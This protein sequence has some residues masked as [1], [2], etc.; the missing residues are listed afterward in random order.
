MKRSGIFYFSLVPGK[1]R[2]PIQLPSG[3]VAYVRVEEV[4]KGM[5]DALALA[6][7]QPDEVG[8]MN[9]HPLHGSDEL[10]ERES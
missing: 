10:M 6:V 1:G 8:V 4:N 3:D 5:S 9:A 7:L 2:Q